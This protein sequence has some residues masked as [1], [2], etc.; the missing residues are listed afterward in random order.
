MYWSG[1]SPVLSLVFIAK[2]EREREAVLKSNKKL[3]FDQLLMIK[4]PSKILI[5]YFNEG[6]D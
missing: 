5:V 1:N 3:I 6:N 2:T 4:K